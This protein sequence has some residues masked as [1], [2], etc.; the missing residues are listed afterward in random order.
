MR[1]QFA[2]LWKAGGL[3]IAIF[4]LTAS[5]FA[6]V[7][8]NGGN[9]V[10]SFEKV[11]IGEH[12]TRPFTSTIAV[13][14]GPE[15]GWQPYTISYTVSAPPPSFGSANRAFALE[16]AEG[17]TE[18]VSLETLIVIYPN[19]AAGSL[20]PAD[21]ERTKDQ[22]RRAAEF[23]WRNSHF[24][25]HLNLT[26]IVIEDFLD[27][28]EFE[29]WSDS[30]GWLLPND[31]DGDGR[32][33]ENDLT[34]LGVTENQFDSINL[35]WAHNNGTI[36]ACYGGLAFR[37]WFWESLGYTMVT[38][39]A[40]FFSGEALW[41]PFH[42]E[43]QHTLDFM[44]YEGGEEAYFH[45]D[46]PQHADGRFGD[47]WDFHAV[48]MRAWPVEKW[49][50]ILNAWG[51]LKETAD[52]D[53][54]GVPDED[55]TLFVTEATIGSSPSLFDSDGDRAS[56]RDEAMA[57]RF[58]ASD[59]NVADSDGD[60][61]TDGLDSYLLYPTPLK[62]D[63]KT[64]PINGVTTR[65]NL[66]T[67]T[68]TETNTPFNAETY[69]NWDNDNIYFMFIVDR[70]T[71][72]EMY[73]DAGGDGFWTG[74]DNYHLVLR[75]NNSVPTHTSVVRRA[76]VW[77]TTNAI[78]DQMGQPM[79]DD[80]PDY[81]DG[82]LVT[83]ADIAR[84]TRGH[85]PNGYI[86]QIAVPRNSDTGLEPEFGRDIG[87]VFWYTRIDS[88]PNRRARTFEE[89]HLVFVP[90][91]STAGG[92]VEGLVNARGVCDQPTYAAQ[93]GFVYATGQD[94]LVHGTWS[95]SNGLYRLWLKER[96]SPYELT[97]TYPEHMTETITLDI[98]GNETQRL[99]MTLRYD[100]T[101]LSVEPSRVDATLKAGER[102]SFGLNVENSGAR[103]ATLLP[104]ALPETFP[105]DG[106]FDGFGYTYADS[107]DAFGPHY[108]WIEIAPE[109]GGGGTA[110]EPF[111]G[112]DDVYVW[113]IDLPFL[114]PFYDGVY[115][116]IGI[117][118]NG[119]ILFEET[120]L[121]G[122]YI[123]R[124]LPTT[125][126]LLG[127]D[128]LIAL[129]WDDLVMESGAS[130]YVQGV[131]GAVVIEFYKVHGFYPTPDDATWQIVLFDNG[132]ILMQFKEMYFG[133]FDFDFGNGATVGIQGDGRTGITYSYNEA[134]IQDELA[135]CFAYP[136][137]SHTCSGASSIPWISSLS[138]S[139]PIAADG[140]ANLSFTLDATAAESIVIG[141][142]RA[143]LVLLSNDGTHI[144]IPIELVVTDA[145]TLYLPV[146]A[147]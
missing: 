31:G 3:F 26:F 10:A 80:D 35:L 58:S 121:G 34:A 39:N 42:H 60:G 84:Y 45:A 9:T 48:Q 130:V 92:L 2:S 82:R 30:C 4:W 19:T 120:N 36:P 134:N 25:V 136:G 133:D 40:L 29:G 61:L 27:E 125:D 117:S 6:F 118:S 53:A 24:K 143:N 135:L 104:L 50:A 75:P 1:T 105:V 47:N 128:R 127:T 91:I 85:G 124:E 12:A 123:N 72:V 18:Y 110:V 43:F 44:L 139:T 93:N 46:Q 49:F 33:V 11:E 71:E 144:V 112:A 17:M 89:D 107:D 68:L 146:V 99:D 70:Y 67:D 98:V 87:L 111:V 69:V 100:Q 57:G 52:A 103:S 7:A 119:V 14:P 78:F 65:W 142:N 8:A 22:V 77:D 23:F 88:N 114:F 101:C 56:D 131:A 54:D 90:L 81:P 113:P 63:K 64:V 126:T 132:N 141:H 115:S 137:R 74:R 129:F 21:I 96:F 13:D 116:Q 86:I 97:F 15:H 59:P 66:L 51:D 140:S 16:P 138:P 28:S 37:G 145:R 62:I 5:L 38:M 41:N 79:W 32:S 95:G 76:H 55:A 94:G 73:L 106:R 109:E 108:S 83:E 20:T 102:G 147:R 122:F